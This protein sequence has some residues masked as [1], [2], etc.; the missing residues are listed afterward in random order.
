MTGLFTKDDQLYALT[1]DSLYNVYG[2]NQNLLSTTSQ[3]IAVGTGS[4]FGTEPKEVM[5]IDGGFAGSSSKN[6]LVE[7][8]FGYLFVDKNKKKVI[9]F[10]QSLEDISLHGL[11]Q[12]WKTNGGLYLYDQIPDLKKTSGFD[13]PVN[14][15]GFTAV[16]DSSHYRI[17]I[18]KLDYQMIDITRY[19]GVYNSGTTYASTDFYT[20]NGVLMT[21]VG[22][23][24]YSDITAFVNKS[25]TF[26]FIPQLQQWASS[27]SYLPTNY[28]PHPTG[29]LAKTLGSN[30]K[31]SNSGAMGQFFNATPDPFIVEL[32]S[33]QNELETKVLDS[34]KVNLHTFL[35]NDSD[36]VTTNTCFDNLHVYTEM[37]SSG[38]IAL[39]PTINLT[40]KEKDWSINKFFDQVI[41]NSNTQLFSSKWVDVNTT[42]P[43]D[44]VIN[45][46]TLSY[47][48]PWYQLG[49]FRD[50][51]FIIRFTKN[52]L[53]NGKIIVNFVSSI[54]RRSVR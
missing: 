3:N 48:K 20:L 17:L 30:I 32:V 14:G 52:N 27:H 4:F 28:L 33:N 41:K 24:A 53:D 46:S 18:T 50:K 45:T 49:R 12:Y 23:A 8:P 39:T 36:R 6:S 10:N 2:S 22:P 38:S 43:I 31:L 13:N 35:N 9:L 5:A 16:Y 29:F 7:T 40:K 37:Q 54:Y 34:L 47:T 19:K 21:T 42:Y 51:Y 25:Y 15:V 1:R 26:S 44:K 11:D